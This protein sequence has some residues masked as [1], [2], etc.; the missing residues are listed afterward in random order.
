[1]FDPTGF[2]TPFVSIVFWRGETLSCSGIMQRSN[3]A[4]GNDGF[5]RQIDRP[6]AVFFALMRAF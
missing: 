5:I 6:P 3:Q 1:M 4:L 2:R